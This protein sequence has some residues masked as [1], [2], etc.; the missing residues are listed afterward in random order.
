MIAVL[1]IVT[2]GF[3]ANASHYSGGN[4]TYT[5]I[6][7]NKYKVTLTVYRDC[8]GIEFGSTQIVN[9]SSAAC[10]VSGSLT[11]NLQSVT[12]I[13]PLCP[14]AT[15]ACAGGGAIGI[16]MQIFEAV[17]TLPPGCNDW[18]LSTELCCRNDAITNLSSPSSNS[19]YIESTLDNSNG[20]NDTSPQFSSIPQFFGCV[21]QT[22]NFQQLAYDVDGDNLTYTLV[23]ALQ[24]SGTNVTYAG[25]FSGA[26]PFTVPLVLDP[27]TGQITFTPDVPQVAVITVLIQEWRGGVLIGSIMRDLQF[28]I[29]DCNNTIPDISGIDGVPGVYEVT[30]CEGAP[31][32]FDINA[33]DMDAGQNVSLVYDNSIPG[34]VFTPGGTA[35]N[36]TGT[37][38]WSTSLGDA[39][40][41]SFTVTSEDDHCPLIGQNSAVYTIN[42]IPNPNSPVNAGPDVA[43]CAGDVV[44]L[45]A[46][47]A[48]PPASIASY[49]WL[50]T[51]DLSSP[52]TASTDASPTTTTS[53]TVTMVYTDGCISQDAVSVI[54]NS[55]PE[56]NVFPG[57]LDVCGGSNITLTGTTD[58]SGMNFEW[59]DP[60][61]V[62]L[63]TGT[64]AGAQS[65]IVVTV[66]SADGTYDYVLIITDPVTGCQSSDTAHLNVGAPSPL[67]S[68]VNI[69]ASTTGSALA[70]GTQA[71]PTSLAEA[72]NRAACNDAVIK[73]ATGTYN[74]DNA[75]NL[76]SYVTLEGGF[77]QGSAWTKTSTPGATTINRTTANPEGAANAQRLVAFYGNGNNGFRLQDLTITTANANQPGMSTYGLHLTGCDGYA[78]ARCQILPGNA[79]NG[80]TGTTVGLVGS[81]GSVGTMGG[82]GSCDGNYSCC[83]GS[84]SAPGGTGGAGGTGAVGV[85]GGA[86]NSSTI[87]NNPGTSGTGRNGGGGGAG[88]KGGGFSGGNAAEVGNDGGGSASAGLNTG[89]GSAGGQGDPGG[90]GGNG[91]AGVNGVN[92]TAGAAGAAGTYAGGFFVPGA[93]AGTGGDG[94]GGQG[95]AGGGGGGRQSCSFCDD[96]PG[97]GGSGGGGGGQGGTGGTGGRGGGASFGLFLVSNGGATTVEQSNINAGN[98]GA[99]GTGAAGGA[100]GTGGNGGARRTTCTSEIGEGGAG[101]KGGNGGAGGQ[102]GTGASGTAIDVYL[103]SGS[104]LTIDVHTFNLAAQPEIQVSNVNCTNTNVQYQD[105]TSSGAT[106]DFDAST[107][108][109]VPATGA[110]NPDIT[111]YNVVDRYDVALGANAYVGFHNIAFISTIGAEIVANAPQIGVDTFMVCVGEYASFES[112]Y[113]ADTYTWN[114]DGAIPNP[115]S[116]QVVSEQFNTPGFFTITMNMTT[117]CCGTTPNDTVYLYVMGTPVVSGSGDLA[118]CE[119]ESGV[120]AVTG[121]TASDSLVWSPT[122]NILPVTATS[123]SVNPTATTTYTATVYST[124]MQGSQVITGCPASID[125]I[126]S[127]NPLPELSFATTDVTCANDGTAS[128][129]VTNPTGVYDFVWE[130]GA[131]DNST[132]TS[133]IT[134][135]ASDNYSVTVTETVTGCAVTDSINVYPSPTVPYVYIQDL[136]GTCA[137]S[138]DGSAIANTVGGT[139]PYTYLWSTGGGGTTLTG[140]AGGNYS[141][142]VTDNLGC[143]STTSFDIP[144]HELPTLS[145]V[146]N[147]PICPGDTAFIALESHDGATLYYNFGGAD[148][149]LWFEHDSMMVIVPNVTTDLTMYIDS[150]G[151]EGCMSILNT[152][153]VVSV[154]TISPTTVTT[155]SPVCEGQDAVFTING[156][157]DVQV[158]YTLNG[159][160][161]QTTTLVGGTSTITVPAVT[162]DQY[163]AL[164]S[165]SDGVCPQPLSIFDTVYV[166]PIYSVVVDTAVCENTNFIYPDGFSEVITANS[167]HVSNLFTIYGCDSTVTTNVTMNPTPTISGNNPI[168]IG[169]TVQLTGSGTPDATTPWSSSDP[170][171]ATIDNT[172]L[173]TGVAAG[174]ATMTYTDANGCQNTEVVTVNPDPVISTSQTPI[175]ACGMNDGVITV[176]DAS[177]ATGVVEWTNVTTGTSVVIT[178]PYDITNAIPGTYDVTFTDDVTGCTSAVSQETFVNPAEPVFDPIADMTACD[179]LYLPGLTGANLSGNEAFWS[180]NG[181]TGTQYAPNDNMTSTM[182]VYMYD[183]NGLCTVE[184]SFLVTIYPTPANAPVSG[185]D[186]VYCTEDIY[187]DM[188][189][190]GN[191]G[192]FT[193]YLDSVLTNVYGTGATMAPQDLVGVTSYYVTETINGCESPASLVIITI[194][195]CNIVIPTA[196]TPDNDGVNDEWEIQNLD[197]VYPN[198]QVFVYNR[199]GTLLY[200]SQQGAYDQDKWDGNYN[201]NQLPVGS[202]FYV[203]K[204]NDEDDNVE[205]GAVSIIR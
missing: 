43:I 120:L 68:C 58:Q 189:A 199:W 9:Y 36:P 187:S 106:W 110:A 205:T 166:N 12:D 115:G 50:P 46:T 89:R 23:N 138:T 161:N 91:A 104:A 149:T 167:S 140:L 141:V 119:G 203:I 170:A 30:I 24:S 179:S 8:N 114:F 175:S 54:V 4:I 97:N 75:L 163:I 93:I 90:D 185:T 165:V 105:M 198:S 178:L 17:L 33:S 15:S 21:G 38:C 19:F 200:Q 3:T 2:L 71:D 182:W 18:V 88:G 108:N 86:T 204:L 81:P 192:T 80:A 76:S 47:T 184:D 83:F 154:I 16:E 124:M 96:G 183:V 63:G 186:S 173:V 11:V 118:F 197:I 159:V 132:T 26:N 95:G 94:T 156:Q 51:T 196:I 202:Y 191:G 107:N 144:E 151:L 35:T 147:S 65:D 153:E 111:Q 69:Y 181:G 129:T 143:S 100:G 177:G 29:E 117:D 13:T 37:F 123:V 7:P 136:E 98:A 172:G 99:G 92:G 74:I 158:E 139:A 125:F 168:C 27:A 148:S 64:V 101:G 193:W 174:T 102:G 82:S 190:S 6:G 40:T 112:L 113:Y 79:G 201:G 20:L 84:E 121:M 126:V 164:D 55:D 10:G 72:L 87:Q 127:V 62:S 56:A 41:Y 53:Y 42:V 155:N 28:I 133:M 34:A 25:G 116:V 109:A 60:T 171:V 169:S 157:A 78:I 128:A 48:A 77:I 52:S 146:T 103:S 73:L 152:T 39:G 66:P 31:V 59:F 188:T 195:E 45:N 194:E 1:F 14:S 131:T 61:P 49:S 130:T 162:V 32:C 137:G 67:P 85:P 5:N 122:V 142:T 145:I 22:I 150:I 176:S 135:L 160:G 70:A 57:T 180:G 44:T 134:G